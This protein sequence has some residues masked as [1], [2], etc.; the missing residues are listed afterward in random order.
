MSFKSGLRDALTVSYQ[1]VCE[2]VIFPAPAVG[3][4]PP[5]ECHCD[6][7]EIEDHDTVPGHS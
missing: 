1:H 2:C 6:H 5:S 4:Y 7:S 3:L